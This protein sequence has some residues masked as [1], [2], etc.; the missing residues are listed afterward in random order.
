MTSKRNLKQISKAIGI[1]V[2]IA[3][4]IELLFYIIGSRHG[5]FTVSCGVMTACPSQFQMF[6]N[7][8]P[9]TFIILFLIII[10]TYYLIKY[11]KNKK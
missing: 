3:L 10:S 7:S 1:S 2:L 4:I 9:Y 8:F 11:F 5:F 6:L